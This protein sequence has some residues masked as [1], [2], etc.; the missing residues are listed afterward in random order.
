[1]EVQKYRYKP[2]YLFGR[3][4]C[5]QLLGLVSVYIIPGYFAQA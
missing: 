5:V 4:G 3:V 1:M 2:G